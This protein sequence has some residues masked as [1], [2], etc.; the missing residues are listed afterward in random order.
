MEANHSLIALAE[1][2]VKQL[3][4]DQVPSAY[5]F[6]DLHH[7][8][9]VVEAARTIASHYTLTEED[10]TAL[11][12]AAWFH[13]TGYS[14]QYEG[15]EQASV[16]I[17]RAFLHARNI[18]DPLIDKVSACILAT[19][20]PQSPKSTIEEIICDA[21][22]YHLGTTEFS[23]EH[24]L[25]RKE[26]ILVF[27]KDISKKDWRKNNIA[28]LQKHSYFTEYARTHLEP[29][30][31][32]H[33][34]RLVEKNEAVTAGKLPEYNPEKTAEVIEALGKSP[35]SNGPDNKPKQKKESRTERGIATMFRIMSDN[36]VSLSQ[37]ADSKANIMIS[38]NTIVL[39][40][41][42]S[43]L[44]GKLQYYPQF[45]I[46]TSLLATVCL[47]AVI[48]AIR[49]TRPNVNKGYFTQE[50]IRMKKIN[51]LF[52]GNFFKMELPD[53]EWAMKEMMNDSDY[54]Y[55]SM[56]KDI[57][58]LG[59]VLAKKYHYLRISYNIF[60][61]GLI[62]SVLAFAIATVIGTL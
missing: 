15:H 28:F 40:I 51:L 49:A 26:W 62:V 13:D 29:V 1:Q 12:L 9:G 52:F 11:M 41:L 50:D 58:Y 16:E 10:R 33:L 60:M 8:V 35:D 3:F 20:M 59:K 37:M 55:G 14:R 48:F 30:K 56:I 2:Y 7:T 22:L 19:Q 25:L 43:V 18:P 34:K 53:Y 5:Q 44:L 54:L 24:K 36:H 32:E 42:V 27:G 4:N 47:S 31:Q 39:S 21:D 17:A 46:P 23:T 38:V 61:Y 57:Y 6:H 45:I